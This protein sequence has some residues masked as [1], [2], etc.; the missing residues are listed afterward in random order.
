MVP[1]SPSASSR[2][3]DVSRG[4]STPVLGIGS[5]PSAYERYADVFSRVYVDAHSIAIAL[6]VLDIHRA[7][8]ARARPA[9]LD[10]PGRV[11]ETAATLFSVPPGRLRE[12]NRRTDVTSARYVAAWV[13]RRHR[14]VYPKIAE[15]FGLN[16]AT[17]IHG[18]RKVS[19]SSHLLL[20]ALKLESI[21]DGAATSASRDVP[22][23]GAAGGGCCGIIGV[24]R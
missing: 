9:D 13:L 2:G 4:S 8:A 3:R 12:R 23:N 18:I 24:P 17:I 22:A 6:E 21:I 20:A 15:L 7:C 1:L 14:W 11:L 19:A 16:H 10:F 5:P